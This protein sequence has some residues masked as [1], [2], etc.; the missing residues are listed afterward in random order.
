M[1][2]G[3][4]GEVGADIAQGSSTEQGI[5]DGVQQSV[6]VGVAEQAFFKGDGYAAEDERAAGH[7]LVDV[8]A[9][10]DAEG[11]EGCLLRVGFGFQVALGHGLP[12][13]SVVDQ[14]AEFGGFGFQVACV[15][16]V[17]PHQKRH[18]F[19]DLNAALRHLADFLGI[20]G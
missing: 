8:V 16:A 18:A 14:M 12:E 15:L 5:G 4:V 6:G 19:G 11:H 20:V 9:L 7:E 13:K 1:F 10:S 3:S 2:G 17:L